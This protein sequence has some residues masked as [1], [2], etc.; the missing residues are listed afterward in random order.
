MM[1]TILISYRTEFKIDQLR[2]W[3]KQTTED[4]QG[5]KIKY[6]FNNEAARLTYYP[7]DRKLFVECSLP[8]I[9]FGNNYSMLESTDDTYKTL[10]KRIAIITHDKIEIEYPGFAS[11]HKI[12]GCYN[13]HTPDQVDSYLNYFSNLP[14]PY[15]G[16]PITFADKTVTW[17][18]KSQGLKFYD[19]YTESKQNPKARNMLRMELRLQHQKEFRKLLNKPKDEQILL[20]HITFDFIKDLLRDKL[21]EFFG[22]NEP[23]EKKDIDIFLDNFKPAKAAQLYGFIASKQDGH[24]IY[25]PQKTLA[26]YRKDLKSINY[27]C[28]LKPLQIK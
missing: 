27:G 21:K 20:N 24:N 28:T 8:K 26:R 19:K 11:I 22:T 25:F 15:H 12:D 23:I 1:D 5:K 18:G 10:Q 3:T 13:F 14:L 9:V 7:L 16:L 17:P 2:D 4:F 6:Y